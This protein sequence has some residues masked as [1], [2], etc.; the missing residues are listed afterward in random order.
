MVPL[1]KINYLGARTRTLSTRW[2]N[3][4]GSRS[5]EIISCSPDPQIGKINE[6]VQ[7]DMVALLYTPRIGGV[8][9]VTWN[10]SCSMGSGQC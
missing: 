5:K 1:N 10:R 7:I 9:I 2:R 4:Q 6:D 3:L 8:N